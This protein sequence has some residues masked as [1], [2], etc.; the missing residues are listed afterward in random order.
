MTGRQVEVVPADYQPS[1]TDLQN[2]AW[3]AERRISKP[4]EIADSNW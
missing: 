4:D 2:L 1:A 3:L